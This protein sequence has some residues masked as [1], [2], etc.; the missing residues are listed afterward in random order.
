[1]EPCLKLH[2]SGFSELNMFT[3][4]GTGYVMVN[5]KRYEHNLIILPDRV[6]EDWQAITF[7]QLTAEHF[8]FMLPLQPEIVLFGTGATLRFPHPSLTK[9]LIASKI[10]VEVMDTSAACRTY[11]IL[12]AE[13]RRVAA[14]LLI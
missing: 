5:R 4:Y 8:E 11:N 2:L 9:A 3:G 12:T 1:M 14:A 7:E 10:G 6:I 13:G